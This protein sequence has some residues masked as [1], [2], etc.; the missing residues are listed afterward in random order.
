MKTQIIILMLFVIAGVCNADIDWYY[1]SPL[2]VVEEI[3]DIGGGNYRYEYSFE[4]VDTSPIWSFGVYTKFLT[5]GEN[6]FT[7]H[8]TWVG[9]YSGLITNIYPEYDARNLDPGILYSNY[10]GYEDGMYGD[11]SDGIDIGESASGFSFVSD[12]FDLIPKY[13]MYETIESG[14]T[15]TNG[16]G[17]VAAVGT[18]VPEPLTLFFFGAGVL[19]LFKRN[20]SI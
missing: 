14:Y 6:T 10:S 3:T 11:P 19:I 12:V 20:K 7:G 4:N 17:K 9:P 15:Q 18:T 5:T 13:Y 2:T 8:S 1:D 16:T